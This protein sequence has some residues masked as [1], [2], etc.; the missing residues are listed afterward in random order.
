MCTAISWGKYFGRNLDLERGYNERV[1]ITPRNYSF[2]MRCGDD[3]TNHYAIIGMAAVAQE[4]PLYFDAMNEKGLCM[5]GLNFPNNAFYHPL[6]EEKENIT[7]F[8]FIPYVLCQCS[9]VKEAEKLLLNINLVNINFS[10]DL[11][12]SPLHWMISD[13]ERSLTVESVKDGLMVYENRVE[14]LT[15][16]PPFL[17]QIENFEKYNKILSAKIPQNDGSENY[18]LGLDAVGLPGDFSSQS[19]FVKAAIVKHR[20]PENLV[21]KAAVNHFFHILSSVAMPKGCVLT[22]EGKNEYTRYTCCCDREKM[23]YYYTTYDNRQPIKLS[24]C[25]CELESEKIYVGG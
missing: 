14:V 10:R 22:P 9:T 20:S 13:N 11:P 4:Y 12:L 15:N 7:P 6:C 1:V 25:N 17:K 24:F 23:E 8:E 16:N 19:R 2:K 5:A 18:S 3:L 21:G